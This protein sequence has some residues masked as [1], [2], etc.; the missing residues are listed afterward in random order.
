VGSPRGPHQ[1]IFISEVKTA[2]PQKR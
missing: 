1:K 2:V